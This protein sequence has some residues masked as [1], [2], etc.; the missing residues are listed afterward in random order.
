MDTI[1]GILN[2]DLFP[3]EYAKWETV[4][5]EG[6]DQVWGTLVD[7]DVE[8]PFY[9]TVKNENIVVIGLNLSFYYALTQ[10]ASVGRLLSRAMS[11]PDTR[12]PA[13]RTVPLKLVYHPNGVDVTTREDH[14]N[15]TLAWHDF[16]WSEQELENDNHL[17]RVRS[18]TTRIRLESPHLVEG[19][20]ASGAGIVLMLASAMWAWR[21]Q[22]R[23]D[24]TGRAEENLKE[25][26]PPEKERGT[27]AE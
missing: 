4:Y 10:D 25:T 1:D 8:L 27:E 22:R 12:L 13:R 5:T 23:Q 6:L 19:A 21:E 17:V 15:T 9:G 2:T 18:G 26:E 20:A 3:Q 24:R 16:L 7:N 14:V 11:L